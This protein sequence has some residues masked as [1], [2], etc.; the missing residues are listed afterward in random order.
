MDFRIDSKSIYWKFKAYQTKRFLRIGARTRIITV[1]SNQGSVFNEDFKFAIH[2][3]WKW[4]ENESQIPVTSFTKMSTDLLAMWD[5]FNPGGTSWSNDVETTLT[6]L[7][8]G[9]L[10]MTCPLGSCCREKL[11]CFRDMFVLKNCGVF[12]SIQNNMF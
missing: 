9:R 8:R 5:T 3:L 1:L 7:F 11:N 12:L 2:C 10:T 4:K 6:T